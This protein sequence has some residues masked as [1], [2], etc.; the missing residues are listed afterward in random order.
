MLTFFIFDKCQ[1]SFC[2]ERAKMCIFKKKIKK[3]YIY[4]SLK[5]IMVEDQTGQY[6]ENEGTVQRKR[7]N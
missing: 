7:K 1:I 4:T 3:I 2:G 6:C 5:S